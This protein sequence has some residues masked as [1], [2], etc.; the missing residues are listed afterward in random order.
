M[1]PSDPPNQWFHNPPLLTWS[2]TSKWIQLF[3]LTKTLSSTANKF[4]K[5]YLLNLGKRLMDFTNLGRSKH[6]PLAPDLPPMDRMDYYMFAQRLSSA[7]QLFNPSL[8]RFQPMCSLEWLLGHVQLRLV[9]KLCYR[10]HRPLRPSFRLDQVKWHESLDHV[11]L[12][13][14]CPYLSGR[15]REE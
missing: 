8:Q 13:L 10:N 12:V 5:A 4:N 3:L 7:D 2:F 14:Y 6:Q 15:G 9:A 1:L 11:I